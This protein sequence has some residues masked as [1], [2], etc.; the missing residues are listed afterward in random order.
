MITHTFPGASLWPVEPIL[1]CDND[2]PCDAGIPLNPHL[3]IPPYKQNNAEYNVIQF[4]EKGHLLYQ[5]WRWEW[6]MNFKRV[7]YTWHVSIWW[8]HFSVFLMEDSNYHALGYGIQISSFVILRITCHRLHS[9][10]TIWKK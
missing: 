6:R 4:M 9:K 5:G 1:R 7:S 2:A 10:K 8:E 3:F